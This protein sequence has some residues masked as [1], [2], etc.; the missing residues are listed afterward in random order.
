MLSFN[1]KS[2]LFA[3]PLARLPTSLSVD[4]LAS[5]CDSNPSSAT[6]ILCQASSFP[7]RAKVKQILAASAGSICL[8]CPPTDQSINQSI[9]QSIKQRASLQTAQAAGSKSRWQQELSMEQPD[10]L[11]LV[12]V[13][14]EIR[15]KWCLTSLLKPFGTL[16]ESVCPSAHFGRR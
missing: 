4:D 14:G 6:L 11:L 16:D 2:I 13:D 7:Q 3:K 5:L 15:I 10:E 12:K 8:V 9:N 1:P